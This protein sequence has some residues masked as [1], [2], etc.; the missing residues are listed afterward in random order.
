MKF[1]AKVAVFDSGLGS[2]SI[3]RSLQKTCKME[4]IYFADQKNF[5]YGTK[6]EIKLEEIIKKTIK[7][8]DAKFS[9]DLII[10][11]SNTPTIIL[12]LENRKIIG[13]NPP[14]NDAIKISKTKNIAVLATK[15]LVNSNKFLNYIESCK[16]PNQ[17][18]IHKINSS[19]LV[20]LVESG[21]FL[22]DENYCRKII[23]RSLK[24]IFSQNKI[25]VATLSSTHLPFLKKIL[26]SEFSNVQ[27]IDPA[28]NLA[29]K[30]CKKIKQS[31]IQ[32]NS[33]KIYSS[34]QTGLFQKNLI[35]MGI[36][37]KIKFF[38]I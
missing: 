5:P 1:M 6:T 14:L 37:K 33:L 2:L 9:P 24:R 25:D 28:D 30:I 22:T 16:L 26:K 27:F 31:N 23:R 34:D 4:I 20:E 7:N 3:I 17:F 18:I 10:I 15:S 32:K 8:L 35:K 36:K 13:V 19:N 29:I 11:G 38:S 21:K 12:G